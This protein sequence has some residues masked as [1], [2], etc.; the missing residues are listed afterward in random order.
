MIDKIKLAVSRLTVDNHFDELASTRKQI[1]DKKKDLEAKAKDLKKLENQL[2]VVMLN[3]L[4][5]ERLTSVKTKSG[6]LTKQTKHSI[7]NADSEAFV[8][9]IGED[10]D[11]RKHLLLARCY[12]IPKVREEFEDDLPPGLQSES[13]FK[14]S[15]TTK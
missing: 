1:N 10:Y 5:Q 9:W 4:T 11:N 2:D 14:L 15:I 13:F 7:V 8:K 12:S 6:V 3:K